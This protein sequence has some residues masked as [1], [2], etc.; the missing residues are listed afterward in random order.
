MLSRKR[1]SFFFGESHM[2]ITV[3][4]NSTLDRFLPDDAPLEHDQ[5]ELPEEE[6]PLSLIE[7]LAIPNHHIH[8]L[9]LNGNLLQRSQ[10]CSS[11]L[12]DG[13]VVSLWPLLA[14]G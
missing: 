12:T 5:L 6:T 4:L 3:E 9:F 2:H 8:L 7:R 1:R 13:D 14:G 11:K 10:W